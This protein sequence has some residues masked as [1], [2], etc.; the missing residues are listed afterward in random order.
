[1]P[2]IQPQM[3]CLHSFCHECI[4]KT[5]QPGRGTTN[6]CPTCGI[7]LGNNPFVEKKVVKDQ[8]KVSIVD[9]LRASGVLVGSGGGGA[10]AVEVTAPPVEVTAPPVAAAPAPAAPAPAAPAPVAAEPAPAAPEPAPAAADP[11]P[12]Q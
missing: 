5:V 2:D 8:V 3:E 1:L 4:V 9:K 11:A 10:A 12:A 6:A 7:K